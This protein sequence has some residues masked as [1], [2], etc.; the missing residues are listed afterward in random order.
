MHL[1]SPPALALHGIALLL[2]AALGLAPPAR[3]F[4][5]V[6]PLFPVSAA[7]TLNW[8]LPTDARLVAAGPYSGSF[9]ISGSRDALFMAAIAHGS[10]LLTARFS[11]CGDK[12]EVV[13]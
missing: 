11:G 1:Q 2:S 10:L 3:G 12:N 9:V 7:A 4:M 6:A 5:L 13:K 8:V